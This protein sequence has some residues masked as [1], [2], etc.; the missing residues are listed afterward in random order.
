MN[1][2]FPMK[3][4]RFSA[5]WNTSTAHKKS[6]GSGYK[7]TNY[8][9]YPTDLAGADT[10]KDWFYAPCDVVCL[11]VYGQASHCL[12]FRSAKKVHMPVGYGYLYFMVEHMSVNGFAKGKKYAKGTKMFREGKAGNASGNHLHISCGWAKDKNKV[13]F[14]SGWIKNNHGAWVLHIKGVTNIKINKAFYLDKDFTKVVDK[15]MAFKSEP[16]PFI[17]GKTYKL[18]ATMNVRAGAGTDHKKKGTCKKGTKIKVLSIKK[19][20]GSYWVKIKDK[21][22]VCARGSNGTNYIK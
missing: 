16:E 5:I 14:G 9:D 21:R 2:T 1:A 18:K 15:R 11:R 12:W 6:S 4:L 8:K 20:K 3:T 10:G 19:V 17:K 22:W 7:S 13:S